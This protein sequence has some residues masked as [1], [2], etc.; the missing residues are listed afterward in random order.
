MLREK[1]EKFAKQMFAGVAMALCVAAVAPAVQAGAAWYESEPNDNPATADPMPV[2]TWMEGTMKDSY[3]EDWYTFTVT[4]PGVTWLEIKPTIDNTY[5]SAN[6]WV[7]LQDANRRNLRDFRAHSY[8][9]YKL[10]LVPGKYYVKVDKWSGT[11]VDGAYDLMVHNEASSLWEQEQYY[12]DKTMANANIAYVNN[13]YSGNLYCSYDVDWYQFKLSG[14]N[15]VSVRFTIDDTVANPGTWK[16]SLIEYNSRKTIETYMVRNNVTL[17][18]DSCSGDLVVKVFDWSST[19]G[20]I[21][22]L[23][24][25]ATPISTGSTGTTTPSQVTKPSTSNTTTTT[26]TTT[27]I[28]KPSA[29]KIT[30]VK[31]GKRKATIRWKKASKATGYYVYR[32]TKA[33]GS[34]KKIAT[35]NGKTSYTDKKSLKSKKKYYYKVVSFRKSG[36]KITK[37]KASGV[38]S[39][40]VK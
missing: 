3:D 16:V 7:Y 8:T 25:T 20:Q 27:K 26:N 2:N 28:V 36:S 13:V 21:Y 6:W 18:V 39:V 5:D 23:Q 12:G 40:K 32:A 15:K 19:T 34:Y 10:G 38:K 22:H 31:A 35:V 29:T 17:N 4:T 33:K 9:D 14:N 24:T 11:G 37:A 30:S 1:V